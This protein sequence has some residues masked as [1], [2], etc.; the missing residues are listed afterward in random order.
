M[1]VV[2]ADGYGHGAVP[3]ARAALRGGADRLGVATPREALA[4]RAAGIDAPLMA[5]LWVPGE[6][7]APAVAAGVDLGVSSLAHLDAVLGRRLPQP[8]ASTSRS[9][10]ASAGTASGR[11]I[12]TGRPRRGGRRRAGRARGCGRPDESPGQ[13]RRAR[14]PL[15]A[16]ADRHLPGGPRR[17]RA[18]VSFRDIGTSRTPRRHRPPGHPLRPGSVRHRPV[19]ARSGA[20][21]RGPH[22][23]HDALR[24]GRAHQAGARRTRRVVR[25]H[26]PHDRRRPRSPWFRSATRTASRGWPVPR[27]RCGSAGAGGASPGAS[28]WTRWSWTAAT[29]RSPSA[30]R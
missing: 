18:P 23:R 4:L 27:E 3:A 20:H 12:S 26:L 30:T 13:R 2:K 7:V 14:R 22:A 5:W 25:P 19:R 17:R 9:T 21:A 1:A 10:P 24:H 29:T 8:P 11:R 16:R 6:D 28:R 15:G